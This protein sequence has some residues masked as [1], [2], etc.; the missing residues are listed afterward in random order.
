VTPDDYENLMYQYQ[1]GRKQRDFESG[2]TMVVQAILADPEFLFRL[3][4]EP[5]NVAVGTSYRIS[6]T[7]LASRLSFFLWS[8]IPDE[9]LV[10]LASKNRL[11]EPVI[12]EQQVR[13]MLK[14]DRASALVESFGSQWLSLRNL[15]DFT[16]TQLKYPDWE[17]NLRQAMRRESEMF[18]ESVLR[19]DR[20]VLDLLTADYTFVNERLARHYGIPNI[21]GP[22]FRRVALGPDFDVR[23]GLLGKGSFLA[24]SSQPDRTSPVKRGVWIMQ[25]ILGTHPPDPP[26]VVP[27]LDDTPT[28]AGGR[29]L[30]VRERMESH[31]KNQPCA[32]CHRIMDP[33]GLSLENFDADGIWRAKDG[34]EGGSTIDPVSEIFDGQKVTG[35]SDL[36]KALLRYSPQ[37]VRTLTEKLMVYALGRGVQYY[38]MPVIRSI[39]RDAAKNNYKFSS[40]VVGIVKSEPFQKRVKAQTAVGN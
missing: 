30:T 21:Y 22:Q 39:V 3:E 17:D 38:D 2:I 26:P 35:P 9:Q 27:P 36:R 24:V 8:S 19:E 23:R 37:F 10:D 16:P 6:D 25:T 40:L 18:V 11:H 28:S 13:R 20:N 34:G 29:V 12:L 14:D 31:R 4:A 7:E 33:I 1:V 32:G 15:N 5:A